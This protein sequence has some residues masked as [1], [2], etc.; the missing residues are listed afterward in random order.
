[1]RGRDFGAAI[2]PG[3]RRYASLLFLTF[4]AGVSPLTELAISIQ[5]IKQSNHDYLIQ[6]VTDIHLD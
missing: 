3:L 5:A 4:T 1:L 6:P 2:I